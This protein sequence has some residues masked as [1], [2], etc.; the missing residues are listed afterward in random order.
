MTTKA[1]LYTTVL[2]A[3]TGLK[4]R[5]YTVDFNLSRNGIGDNAQILSADMFEIT[6]VHRFEED[7]N[8]DEEAVVY[9]IE[10]SNG[11]KGILINGYGP[12][13]DVISDD[14]VR[15]LKIRQ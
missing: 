10:S 6:E 14:M 13:S 4:E 3:I 8:P 5:G 1:I 12:S 2:D 11:T 15:K 7:T 9:A